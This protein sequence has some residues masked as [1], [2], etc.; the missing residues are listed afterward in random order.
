MWD[1][2][3]L[4]CWWV[5]LFWAE[6][7]AWSI[8]QLQLTVLLVPLVLQGFLG[9]L[10][11][12]ASNVAPAI[13]CSLITHLLIFLTSGTLWCSLCR[14]RHTLLWGLAKWASPLS[15]A[16]TC[17]SIHTISASPTIQTGVACTLVDVLVT[18]HSLPAWVTDADVPRSR[19]GGLQWWQQKRMSVYKSANMHSTV[20][21]CVCLWVF[22]TLTPKLKLDTLTTHCPWTQGL[23]VWQMLLVWVQPFGP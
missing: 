2:M 7:G 12:S 19:S 20:C 9:L 11:R 3:R 1:P 18:V 10:L 23:L 21:L 22:L 5:F 16:G 6:Y 8:H 4:R 17:E 14:V 13:P 15:C